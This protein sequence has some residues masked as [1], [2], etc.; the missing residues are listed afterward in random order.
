MKSWTLGVQPRAARSAARSE[1]P[2]TRSVVA[3]CST[4]LPIRGRDPV[5]Y[6]HTMFTGSRS[7][8]S[9]TCQCLSVWQV[10]ILF[11]L[12]QVKTTREDNQTRGAIISE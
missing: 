5:H 2:L 11:I 1:L 10:V 6:D 3:V 8:S 9:N 7:L 12:V 4:A